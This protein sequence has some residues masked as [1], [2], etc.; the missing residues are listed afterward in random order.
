M[1]GF[2]ISNSGMFEIDL[3]CL[4]IILYICHVTDATTITKIFKE[5]GLAF[6]LT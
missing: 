4:K 5:D 3:Y 6:N 2:F 1:T